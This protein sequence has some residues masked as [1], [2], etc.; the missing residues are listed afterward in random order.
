MS[1]TQSSG[2]TS[3]EDSDEDSDEASDDDEMVDWEQSETDA[4]S[5]TTGSFIKIGGGDKGQDIEDIVPDDNDDEPDYYQIDIL[6]WDVPC[7]PLHL[8][9]VGG[10]EEA[11]KQLCD[12]SVST[13]IP[14][15]PFTDTR[16]TS[17]VPIPSYLS[18][19]SEAIEAR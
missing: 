11:V 14:L 3:D 2:V 8:A 10:H 16:D 1:Q 5:A 7:S 9:I 13:L 6:A 19:S 18:S 4:H 12:V 17:T 15:V